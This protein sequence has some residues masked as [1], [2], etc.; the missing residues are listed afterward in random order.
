MT[1]HTF[2]YVEHRPMLR[3]TDRSTIPES[4]KRKAGSRLATLMALATMPAKTPA[5]KR[6]S[7]YQ[8]GDAKLDADVEYRRLWNLELAER[9]FAVRTAIADLKRLPR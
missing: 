3:E 1:D 5:M 6:N 8:L 9:T 7:A 2:C 4:V